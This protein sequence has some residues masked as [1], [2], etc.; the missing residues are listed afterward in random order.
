MKKTILSL[1]ICLYAV[2]GFTQTESRTLTSR[3]H[4]K[5]FNTDDK[6]WRFTIPQDTVSS[7]NDTLFIAGDTILTVRDTGYIIFPN[8]FGQAFAGMMTVQTDSLAGKNQGDISYGLY[9]AACETCPYVAI[10]STDG[11]NTT[12]PITATKYFQLRGLKLKLQ[13]WRV[14]T[15]T[16]KINAS[17]ILKP[18]SISNNA[19][20]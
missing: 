1:M 16:S 18:S 11:Q 9:Q 15:G 20:N 10:T 17:L 14:G 6:A 3:T 12:V 13:Y 4:Y 7:I 2:L 8:E 19:S 5:F